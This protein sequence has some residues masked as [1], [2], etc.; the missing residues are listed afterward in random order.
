MNITELARS[1]GVTPE[2][3][4]NKLPEL[5]FSIGQRAIKVDNR[6]AGKIQKAWGE[7]KRRERLTERMEAQKASQQVEETVKDKHVA[8]PPVLSVKEFA[9]RLG[10]PIPTVMQELMRAGILASLNENIDF[11]TASI[12]AGDL[13]YEATHEEETRAEEKTDGVE[14][15]EQVLTES[16][17]VGTSRPPVVVVMGHVDHGKTKLLDTI[18][19]THVIDTEAGGIT[20]HIGAYQTES[21]GHALTFIDTPGHE[22]FT[23]MRSRG[24]KVADIAILVVAADDG[25][26]P[27]TQ[28]AIDIIK[29]AKMPFV[30]AL[31]KIDLP[32][33]NVDR[34]LGELAEKG[35]TPEAWGG[36]TV[37]V[38]ISAKKGENIDKLLE[39]L[40]LVADMNKD[41][42]VADTSRKGIG[43]IIDSQISKVEGPVA[44]VLVQTGTVRVGDHLGIDGVLYGKVRAMKNWAG[45]DVREA[46][47]SMPVKVL[48]WKTTPS[49]GD[50]MEVPENARDLIKQK[51]QTIKATQSVEMTAT[52]HSGA[53]AQAKKHRLP[54]IVKADV[55]GSLEALM[56]LLDRIQHPDVGVDVVTRGLGSVTDAEINNAE[57]SGAVI[58]AFG[59][60]PTTTAAALARDRAVEIVQEG[61]IYKVIE[62]IL[63][64]LQKLLPDAYV[65]EELGA[66][67]VLATFKKLANGFIVGGKVV[68]GKVVPGVNMRIFRAQSIIGEGE[69]LGV[70]IG[71]EEVREARKGAECGVSY[72]GKVKAEVGDRIEF[73]REEFK[74]RKL[75][76][77]GMSLR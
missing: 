37:T 63:V 61:V 68:E 19:Q 24:A 48:G 5:G 25:I 46:L 56:G 69:V 45:Q 12:L 30:V 74:G 23:V 57:A 10:L 51:F 65:V 27:Q 21:N 31:N 13:G 60:K 40:L 15:L 11:D 14:R 33:A 66:L 22:A 55:L 71:V 29:A 43:T 8:L 3:L 18:R 35:L 1:L 28:E 53:D 42:I 75:Q 58:Y 38:P 67:E 17:K 41:T 59:V 52:R 76:I 54:I 64:R 62:D 49:V 39:M 36:D 20:Q 7:M 32:G 77:E 6:I 26:Q 73:Y 4:H 16:R 2:E 50:V 70:K 9:A 34:V 72:K 44:T 47:P